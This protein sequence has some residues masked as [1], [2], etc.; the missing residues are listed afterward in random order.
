MNK[1]RIEKNIMGLWMAP[2]G[3]R[4]FKRVETLLHSA[5]EFIAGFFSLESIQKTSDLSV[6]S[7][8][9]VLYSRLSLKAT[10][11]LPAKVILDHRI[12]DDNVAQE[13]SLS[14]RRRWDASAYAHNQDKLDVS[15]A[16]L[17]ARGNTCCASFAYTGQVA[18][19]NIML[20]YAS[21]EIGVWVT[22]VFAVVLPEAVVG[23][24]EKAVNG[25]SLER[26]GA[27]DCNRKIIPTFRPHLS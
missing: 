8:E 25:I 2:T 3:S 10:R 14:T 22:W 18:Q 27:D 6:R 1:R 15:I 26:E 17:Q 16:D 4:L 9:R 20:A 23:L 12:T 21:I 11:V 7:T 5:L 24:I 19:N 13:Y